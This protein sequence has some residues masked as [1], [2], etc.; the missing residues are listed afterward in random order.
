MAV[1]PKRMCGYRKIGGLYLV[2]GAPRVDCD[3]LPYPVNSCPV[4]GE[5][6]HQSRSIRWLDGAKFFGGNCKVFQEDLKR[7]VDLGPIDKWTSSC[8]PDCAICESDNLGRVGLMWVGERYYPTPNVFLL[9]AE[10]IGICKK[11]AAVPKDIKLRETW[12][13]LAHP[14]VIPPVLKV[15]PAA[16]EELS[17]VANP[18][19]KYDPAIF[20]AFQPIRIEKLVSD[21]TPQAEL[22][23]LSE[24]GITPVPID[25][26]DADHQ[27]RKKRGER[28]KVLGIF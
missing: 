19:P 27:P 28:K 15:E 25:H 12:I 10:N 22:Q 16:E 21:K 2:G 1:E 9:E 11:I 13:L 23:K 17:V 8:H 4:C 5:G 3:R 6:I 20:Y 18:E 14:A 24:R 26:R 7:P